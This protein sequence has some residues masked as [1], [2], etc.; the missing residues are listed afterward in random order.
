MDKLPIEVIIEVFEKIN[1]NDF[2]TFVKLSK[3]NKKFYFVYNKYFEV[4]VR[5][6]FKN[7]GIYVYSFLLRPGNY[8][9]SGNIN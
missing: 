1:L 8:Q 9:P 4:R 6:Y 2:K 7:E 5:K 3:I